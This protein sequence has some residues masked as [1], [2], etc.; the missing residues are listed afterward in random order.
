MQQ[1]HLILKNYLIYCL[2]NKILIFLLKKIIN[3]IIIFYYYILNLVTLLSV[4]FWVFVKS[5]RYADQLYEELMYYY[6]KGVRPVKNTSEPLRVKFGASLIR[7]IDV[8]CLIIFFLKL[9]FLFFKNL[10]K[11]NYLFQKLYFSY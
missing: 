5:S 2:F 4:C 9:I 6:N 3:L 7:I 10:L 1:K 8:V 11:I